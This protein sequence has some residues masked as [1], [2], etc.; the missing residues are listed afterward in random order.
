V[1]LPKGD[2][3]DV[4]R[5]KSAVAKR[6][7]AALGVALKLA[8]LLFTINEPAPALTSL[9]NGTPAMRTDWADPPLIFIRRAHR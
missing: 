1:G 3:V 7:R 6:L 8:P 2:R 5:F 9:L 4:R